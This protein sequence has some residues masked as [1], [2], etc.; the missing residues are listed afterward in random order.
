MVVG[1]PTRFWSMFSRSFDQVT[2]WP[3]W[4][5]SHWSLLLSHCSLARRAVPNKQ[6]NC[7]EGPWRLNWRNF[8][9]DQLDGRLRFLIVPS[10]CE[11]AP[12]LMHLI[13]VS[14]S[15]LAL[16]GRRLLFFLKDVFP[17]LEAKLQIEFFF[18][19]THRST[20]PGM[21]CPLEPKT[22]RDLRWLRR[23]QL[24]GII[25]RSLGGDR[26]ARLSEVERLRLGG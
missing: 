3:G 7:P 9:K 24:P 2:L 21:S 17:L 1:F 14:R 8:A 5:A 22:C 20:Y 19:R 16:Y 6:P 15:I 10:F 25:P 4:F 12:R 26:K 13:G 23:G 18:K 11:E